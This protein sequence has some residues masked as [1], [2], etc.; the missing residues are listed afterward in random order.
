MVKGGPTLKAP[1]SP[2]LLAEIIATRKATFMERRDIEH[3]ASGSKGCFI[4][5]DRTR[6]RS[7]KGATGSMGGKVLRRP[8]QNLIVNGDV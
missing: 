4:S 1:N 6:L 3:E 2:T 7:H 8:V 5:A